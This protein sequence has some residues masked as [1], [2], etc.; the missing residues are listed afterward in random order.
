MNDYAENIAKY[1]EKVSEF[2]E[3]IDTLTK[4]LQEASK[5]ISKSHKDP[6]ALPGLLDTTPIAE[7]LKLL[8]N[9]WIVLTPMDDLYEYGFGS[10]IDE[11]TQLLNELQHPVEYEDPG[12]N[13]VQIGG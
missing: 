9:A 3:K 5:V 2:H 4:S 13:L 11:L 1:Y 8:Q 7:Q 6:K 10:D 12:K